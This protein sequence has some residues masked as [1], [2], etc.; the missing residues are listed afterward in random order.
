MMSGSTPVPFTTGGGVALSLAGRT[1]VVT[2]G[3]RGIGLGI[4]RRFVE[5]GARVILVARRPE[6]LDRTRAELDAL[7]EGKTETIA[8][9][10]GDASRV[11]RLAD[12]LGGRAVD[13]LVNNAGASNRHPFESI[14]DADWQRDFD[15]KLFAA[16]R[17]SRAVLPGMKSRRWGRI[18]NVVSG[19]GKTPAG[20]GAPTC[21]ARAAGIALTKVLADEYAPH[22]VLVNAL[23]TGV[24]ESDQLERRH[25]ASGRAVSYA[26]FVAEEARRIPVGRIG[27]AE[28]YANVALFL[29]SDAGSYV[30][31]A[32]INVDGGLCRVV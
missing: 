7:A 11:A 32:A 31:G 10:V 4:A 23:C 13:V 18:L 30:T 20:G 3:S 25:A 17:L 29:A 26:E 22:N 15:L 16:I 12:A 8:C 28:E 2:G 9:D 14:T 5:A 27:T 6:I 1:A 24:I 19:N 21:V